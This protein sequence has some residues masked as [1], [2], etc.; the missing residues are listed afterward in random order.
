MNQSTLARGTQESSGLFSESAESGRPVGLQGSAGDPHG[1]S[2]PAV[3][4]ANREE[5]GA[6]GERDGEGV[7]RE[8]KLLMT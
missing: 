8:R 3:N 2:G 4:E 6:A 7:Y 1:G 5:N